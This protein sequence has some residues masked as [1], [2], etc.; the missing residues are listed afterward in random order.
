[1]FDSK[2]IT[3]PES[4]YTFLQQRLQYIDQHPNRKFT[5]I[6]ENVPQWPESPFEKLTHLISS[7]SKYELCQ[8]QSRLIDSILQRDNQMYG[9]SLQQRHVL[10]TNGALHGLSLIFRDL[11]QSG[12]TALCQA[13]VL[14]NISWMLSDIGYKT[15]YFF[16]PEGVINFEKLR[17]K[18]TKEVR[19]IYINTPLNPTGDVLSPDTLEQLV[20]FATERKIALVMDMVYDA[21][22]F[23]TSIVYPF[24]YS[25]KWDNLYVVNSMSKNYGA[26]GLRVGWALSDS[27]NISRLGARLDQESLSVCGLAQDK[28]RQ[29]LMMD[30]T[31]LVES[32][33]EGKYLIEDSLSNY[34]YIDFTPAQGG[35]QSFVKLPVND[36]EAF[37][38]YMLD[39]YGLFFATSDH[40]GGAQGSYIRIPMGES[41]IVL[42][43]ALSMLK[44]G[45]EHSRTQ[46][47]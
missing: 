34:P 46:F 14:S 45:I 27:S 41:V 12:S 6:L 40:Y 23:D 9:I 17:E 31:P 32:V 15:S 1:M 39:E 28:A 4:P 2:R 11:Y 26:P 43:Q 13:P 35:V 19:V 30:N 16:T 42:K 47:E 44:D 22:A 25:N 29:L 33:L 38:D 21:F 20:H 7:I 24:P 8:G 18:C 5:S 37:A 3:N 10:V 36:I